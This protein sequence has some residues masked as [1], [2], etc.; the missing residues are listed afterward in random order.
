VQIVFRRSFAKDLKKTRQ[1]AL[2]QEVQAV[3]EQ[4]EQIAVLHEL[5]R[6]NIWQVTARTI[7]FESVTTALV[8]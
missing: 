5:H 1:K 3:I 8:S 4:I 6:L 7:A 2:R